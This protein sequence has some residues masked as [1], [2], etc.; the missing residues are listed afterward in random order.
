MPRPRVVYST[1]HTSDIAKSLRQER[2][3]LDPADYLYLLYA[4]R[5]GRILD[6][7]FD[8][9]CRSKFN[10]NGAD[11][12]VLLALRRAAPDFALRPTELFRALLV[13]SGAITKQVDRL[14][15]SGLAKRQSGPHKSGGYL[16]CLTKAGFQAADETLT[17]LTNGAMVPENVLTH[18][19]RQ[20]FIAI[21]E[22]L[23]QAL[24]QQ[25]VDDELP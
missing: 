2:A 11:M 12:R 7:I 3:D 21:F 25:M 16:I 19:E 22:K 5:T 8:R 6:T 10:I 4:E 9:F 1:N 17:A 13:T 20:T 18:R 15:A 14:I 24:E 23:L